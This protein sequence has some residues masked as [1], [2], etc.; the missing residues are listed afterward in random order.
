MSTVT[1]HLANGSALVL[2]RF[3]WMASLTASWTLAGGT[4]AALLTA[5]FVL[6]GRMHPDLLTSSF[7]A[8]GGAMLGGLHGVVLGYIGRSTPQRDLDPPDLDVRFPRLMTALAA[9][10]ALLLAI[11]LTAWLGL[12]S[13]TARTGASSG[14]GGLALASP[15]V[16]AGL[17]W[18]TLLGWCAVENAYVRWPDHRVGSLLILG[19]FAVL[20][21][22]FVA[23]D[24]TVP[25][26][27]LHLSRPA[28]IALAALL[29]LWLA[30][31]AIYFALRLLHR[32]P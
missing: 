1:T 11:L 20:M 26:T 31:P 15:I 7:F 4:M 21:T 9:G 24:R 19:A 5:I 32:R 6:T 18:A 13:A 8:T 28:G 12:A 16:A 10:F 17:V 3:G 2:P 27:D 25:G 29:T 22:L 14:W 30:A 23:I